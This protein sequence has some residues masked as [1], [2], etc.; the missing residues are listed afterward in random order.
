MYLP[1]GSEIAYWASP[2]PLQNAGVSCLPRAQREDRPLPVRDG[3]VAATRY[4]HGLTVVTRNVGH[5]QVTGV[6]VLNRWPS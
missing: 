1:S 3:I 2:K 5:F 6:D 4:E